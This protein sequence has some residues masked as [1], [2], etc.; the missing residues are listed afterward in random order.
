MS[1]GPKAWQTP[2]LEVFWSSLLLSYSRAI[3]VTVV[4]I[5][6]VIVRC[7]CARAR[8]WFCVCRFVSLCVWACMHVCV[9]AH[10]CCKNLHIFAT[11]TSNDGCPGCPFSILFH[12]ILF[13]RTEDRATW[14]PTSEARRWLSR[15]LTRTDIIL[16]V[17]MYAHYILIAQ[18]QN[19][20]QEGLLL[21]CTYCASRERV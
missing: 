9:C 11:M 19:H 21:Q 4:V 8:T 7:V 20:R 17:Y 14:R 12:S 10:T 5:V 18:L 13:L 6:I 15:N 3:A 2:C 16:H 1:W